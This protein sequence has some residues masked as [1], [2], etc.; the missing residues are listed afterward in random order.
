[1]YY[2]MKMG[3]KRGTDHSVFTV[4]ILNFIA[5]REARALNEGEIQFWL[6]NA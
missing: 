4:D 6:M 3:W 2:R 5:R 1:M